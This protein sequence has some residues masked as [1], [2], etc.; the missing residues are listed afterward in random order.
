MEGQVVAGAALHCVGGTG[1][2][3]GLGAADELDAGVH[4]AAAAH[5]V[6]GVGRGDLLEGFHQLGIGH[7]PLQIDSLT[8]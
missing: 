5:D 3:L 2:H 8:D 6:R 1:H 4:G 7:V